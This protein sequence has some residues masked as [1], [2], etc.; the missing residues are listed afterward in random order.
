MRHLG[1][2]VSHYT[3]KLSQVTQTHVAFSVFIV[4]CAVIMTLIPDTIHLRT[5]FCFDIKLTYK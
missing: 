5:N 1:L 4:L 2:K 3:D